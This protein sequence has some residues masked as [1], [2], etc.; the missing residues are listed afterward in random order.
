MTDRIAIVGIGCIFPGA[1]SP[2]AF[3]QNILSGRREMRPTPPER[4]PDAYYHPD[5]STPATTHSQRMAVIRDWSF[6]PVAHGIPPI[7][8]QV[9][10][11]SHWLALDVA[12]RTLTDSGIDLRAINLDRVGVIIGNSMTGEFYRSHTLALRWPYVERAIREAIDPEGDNEAVDD[13]V[14]QTKRVFLARL[15]PVTEDFLPGNM[16]NTIA[17]RICNYFDFRGCGYT[18]DGA[19]SSS[20]IAISQACDALVTGKLEYALAGGVDISLGPFEMVGFAKAQAMSRGDIMPF[21]R[22]AAG[23]V[24]GEGCGMVLLMREVDARRQGLCCRA[25]IRGWGT[26]SD[27]SRGGMTAPDVDGQRLALTRTYDGTDYTLADVGLV[28]GHGTGTVLGDRIEIAALLGAIADHTHAPPNGNIVRLG[29]VKAN[30][31]HTKAAAGLAGLIKIIFAVE[32]KILPPA[33]NREAPHESLVAQETLRLRLCEG[34]PWPATSQA[35]RASVSAMG[36]GGSNA[37]VTIEEASPDAAP[38]TADLKILGSD[39]QSELILISG[40]DEAEVRRVTEA[41]L[42]VARRASYAELTDLSAHFAHRFHNGRFRL[43]VVTTSPW[44]LQRSLASVVAAMDRGESW[45]DVDDPALDVYTGHTNDR[46]RLGILCPGQGSQFLNMGGY[47]RRRFPFVRDRLVSFDDGIRDLI[48]NGALAAIY[49]ER[50][51][52]SQECW[53]EQE[54]ALADTRVT[55]PA[56][57]AVSLV[58]MAVLQRFGLTPDV[59]VGHSLGEL[60]ALSIAGAFDAA[61]CVRLA[62]LRGQAM[63]SQCGEDPGRML[64]IHC[65]A[66]EVADLMAPLA[67][68]LDI[69]NYNAPSRVVV[70][71]RSEAVAQLQRRCKER[72]VAAVPLRTSHAFHSPIVAPA[73]RELEGVLPP[74]RYVAGDTRVISTVTGDA[75]DDHEDLRAYLGTQIKQPV[76]FLQAMEHACESEPDLWIELGPGR[77][78]THLAGE[79]PVVEA[80]ILPLDASGEP[81]C[82]LWNRALAT[83]FAKGFDV[84]TSELFSDR[85]YR[86]LDPFDYQPTFIT[87][88]CENESQLESVGLD[89]VVHSTGSP[90]ASEPPKKPTAGSP[91]GE[92]ESDLISE[93]QSW[94]ARRTGYPEESIQPDQH[95]RND[96]HLDSIKVTE[97]LAFISRGLGVELPVAPMTFIDHTVRDLVALFE[98][99]ATGEAPAAAGDLTTQNPAAIAPL[100][101]WVRQFGLEK[102]ALD[103]LPVDAEI[104]QRAVCFV[105]E[106]IARAS[107]IVARLRSEGLDVILA[108]FG[109][110]A[111]PDLEEI[112][113]PTILVIT[114]SAADAFWKRSPELFASSLCRGP[115]ALFRFLKATLD[116]DGRVLFA[117]IA[118]GEPSVNSSIGPAYLKSLRQERKHLE[119]RWVDL[120]GTWSAQQ[121][122]D[123][124][125]REASTASGPLHVQY[126]G[127]SLRSTPVARVAHSAPRG[128]IPPFDAGDLVLVSGGGKGITFELAH[129]LAS[130]YGVRLALLGSSPPPDS[131]PGDTELG[132]NLHRL[133]KDDISYLYTSCDVSDAAAVEQAVREIEAEFGPIAGLLHGAGIGGLTFVADM[134]VEELRRTFSVK[135][136]GLYHILS[137]LQ[138]ERLK[139]VHVLSSVGSQVGLGGQAD[140][141]AANAWLNE[142][143]ESLKRQHP[144]VHCLALNYSLWTETGMGR[145]MGVLENFHRRGGI[146]ITPE[147]ACAGYLKAAERPQ[148]S[149]SDSVTPIIMSRLL[150]EWHQ[151]LFGMLSFPP[152]RFLEQV[153]VCV[154]DV[155]LISECVLEPLKDPYL[156]DHCV[157]EIPVFPAVMAIEAMVQ[158]AQTVAGRS[159]LPVLKDLRFI[160]PIALSPQ[161]LATAFSDDTK[162][163]RVFAQ[164]MDDGGFVK[165]V[166]RSEDEPT[167][168]AV[169]GECWFEPNS[170]RTVPEPNVAL[171]A[172]ASEAADVDVA[173]FRPFPLF[174]GKMFDLH[175]RLRDRRAGIRCTGEIVTPKRPIYFADSFEQPTRTLDPATTDALYQNAGFLFDDMYLPTR[176]KTLRFLAPLEEG[177]TAFCHTEIVDSTEYSWCCN[178]WVLD[179]SGRPSVIMEGCEAT[180]VM[181]DADVERPQSIRRPAGSLSP[182]QVDEQLENFLAKTPHG[183]SLRRLGESSPSDGNQQVARDALVSCLKRKGAQDAA[184]HLSVGHREDGKPYFEVADAQLEALLA[185]QDL[186]IADKDDLSVAFVG[187]GPVG[188]DLEVVESRDSETWR[189][190]LGAEGYLLAQR[191]AVKAN[192]SFDRAASRVWTVMEVNKK[193]L[194]RTHP[195]PA[196]YKRFYRSWFVFSAV[197]GQMRLFLLSTTMALPQRRSAYVMTLGYTRSKMI[198]P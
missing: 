56:I 30:I 65:A 164:V 174:Q 198:G 188:V 35:R 140:Y 190:L 139:A 76:R 70:S 41:A 18:V 23:I 115:E 128:M 152:A 45:L 196:F 39:Q 135:V 170:L 9:S 22:H 19:C 144:Q 91:T 177:S 34:L 83:A 78:L 104:D 7:T 162:R 176:T 11:L 53:R 40:E 117:Q 145:R 191:V 5:P 69:S 21:S 75:I 108:D 125:L 158:A 155:E 130:S 124:V 81:A 37:H 3:W 129:M 127:A 171:D 126:D 103:P 137:Q 178:G 86:E 14:A 168:D 182:D 8:Y 122:C 87:N 159:D 167:R 72:E 146:A 13:L 102:I 123:H 44:E 172:P 147:E 50:C 28:E 166:I 163:I 181:A 43:A 64:A 141:C 17:G 160:L 134:S 74:L 105:D 131:I 111:L 194:G 132:K 80:P 36:F 193:A 61:T 165:T 183:Y 120:P 6:D 109:D 149:R 90:R 62:A 46:R 15:P 187:P 175:I 25:L 12:G 57:A 47:L 173:S 79:M 119:T 154:P 169:S 27:G 101:R 156:L 89:L 121:I 32:R 82:L 192:E 2:E 29:S 157:G 96:L 1:D 180:K 184:V 92:V 26:S 195:L 49:K 71:G 189:A 66:D 153:R 58:H 60:V 54:R 77:V 24:L 73:A 88:P 10:D 94:I 185:G 98:S 112:D 95:L 20:L 116:H 151:T 67:A 179:A 68:D 186:S 93:V 143:I 107:D 4:L 113:A 106:G 31:G 51:G 33:L 84:A 99:P 114:R 59:L 161:D 150:P 133:A 52:V 138:P 42:R 100:T 48:P 148:P 197:T 16:S 55:Q 118:D 63:S 38:P 85:F 136:S 110:P 142:A 97:L